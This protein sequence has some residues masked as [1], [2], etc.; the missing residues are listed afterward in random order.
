[1]ATVAVDTVF[2]DV[3]PAPSE[4]LTVLAGTFTLGGTYN[5]VG[6]TASPEGP[7]MRHDRILKIEKSD[8]TGASFRRTKFE[9]SSLRAVNFTD[10]SFDVAANRSRSSAAHVS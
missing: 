4:V 10:A 6:W 1:M 5:K 2:R 9:R 8:A 3:L 7:L